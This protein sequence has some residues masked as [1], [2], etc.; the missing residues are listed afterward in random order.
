MESLGQIESDNVDFDVF[1]G[2]TPCIVARAYHYF[3]VSGLL[4]LS[5]E[6]S[7]RKRLYYRSLF[8][9]PIFQYF[10][11]FSFKFYYID[12]NGGAPGGEQP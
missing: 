3:R 11:I 12:P 1:L 6:E 7:I 4:G 8:E 5:P 9:R 2:K 10:L